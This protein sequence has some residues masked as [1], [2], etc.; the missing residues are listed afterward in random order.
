MK[1]WVNKLEEAKNNFKLAELELELAKRELKE[2]KDIKG[3][4]NWLGYSFESSSGLTPEFAEFRREVKRYI[5]KILPEELE[6]IMPF[7]SLHFEFSGFIK[8]K[9]TGK[10]VYFSCSDVR[11]FKDSWYDDLLIRTA[12]NEKDYTGGSNNS[13]KITEVSEK[14]KQ[15]T[16]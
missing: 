16:E 13:C 2:K 11:F 7:G 6:L 12:E 14:A 1:I 15:L 3:I 9:K 5:K 8:N 10:F 4:E